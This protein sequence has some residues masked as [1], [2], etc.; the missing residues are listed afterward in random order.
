MFAKDRGKK[1]TGQG[2]GNMITASETST[3][4]LAASIF[5]TFQIKNMMTKIQTSNRTRRMLSDSR[6]ATNTKADDL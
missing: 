3:S 6:I 2:W 5:L 1:T 4:L